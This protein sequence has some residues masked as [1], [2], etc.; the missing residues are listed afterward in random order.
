MRAAGARQ[1]P[2]ILAAADFLVGNGRRLPCLTGIDLIGIVAFT[3]FPLL[4][5]LDR[6]RRAGWF[7]APGTFYV[8]AYVLGWVLWD[9]LSLNPFHAWYGTWGD[10]ALE[11]I[12]PL[13]FVSF[14]FFAAS[15]LIRWR[16][17]LRR[18]EVEETSAEG[19]EP[20]A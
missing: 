11:W 9:E 19:E 20:P 5:I 17:A 16:V 2:S 8:L 13:L 10:H 14:A 15:P 18:Q 12:H 3:M 1:M 6:S 7:L 4:F